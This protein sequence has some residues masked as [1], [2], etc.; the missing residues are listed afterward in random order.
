[1]IWPIKNVI[2]TLI[3]MHHKVKRAKSISTGMGD[4]KP[5]ISMLHNPVETAEE[6]DMLTKKAARS[7]VNREC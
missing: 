5:V 6:L 2:V 4:L 7:V 3:G 1:M